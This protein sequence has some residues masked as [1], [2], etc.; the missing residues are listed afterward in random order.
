M[1]YFQISKARGVALSLL[2][3]ATRE[4]LDAGRLGETHQRAVEK[5]ALSLKF[6]GTVASVPWVIADTMEHMF[7]LDFLLV[8]QT[9]CRTLKVP[10]V[11][12]DDVLDW[13]KTGNS[14]HCPAITAFY[15]RYVQPPSSNV[16]EDADSSQFT[17]ASSQ[18]NSHQRGGGGNNHRQ[19]DRVAFGWA[20]RLMPD[21]LF[22]EPVT[23][24]SAAH[25]GNCLYITTDILVVRKQQASNISAADALVFF[26]DQV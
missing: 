26:C 18:N 9:L 11:K 20:N 10:V 8:M 25:I 15:T 2:A 12:L 24:G 6:E 21:D 13:L 14:A 22:E 17:T 16:G 3:I 5:T 19:Q 7:G 1:R 4:T 23:H